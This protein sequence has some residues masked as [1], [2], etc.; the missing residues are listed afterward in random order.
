MSQIL[1]VYYIYISKAHQ[2][3]TY[4]C[5]SDNLVASATAC[6]PRFI[7]LFRALGISPVSAKF[8]FSQFVKFQETFKCHDNSSA[9]QIKKHV[10][11]IISS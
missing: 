9:D 4:S 5:I 1:Y 10:S 11:E 3:V 6:H 7:G 2:Y 8:N